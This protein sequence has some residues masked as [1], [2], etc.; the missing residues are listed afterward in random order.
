MFLSN[1]HVLAE[2]VL[3]IFIGWYD[4]GLSRRPA[5]LFSMCGFEPAP[6]DVYDS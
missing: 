6:A 3:V 2:I 4:V 1:I 5:V